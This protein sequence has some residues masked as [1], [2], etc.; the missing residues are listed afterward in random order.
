MTTQAAA[1]TLKGSTAIVTEFFKASLSSILYQRG[2]FEE[3]D[4]ETVT[5]YDTVLK[6]L[7]NEEVNEYVTGIL[8]KAS[9]WLQRGQLK[10]F[11]VVLQG[12]HSKKALERWEFNIECD[13]EATDKTKVHKS[14]KQIKQEI[15]ML[16]KQILSTNSF[17]PCLNEPLFFEIQSYVDKDSDSQGWVETERVEI[18]NA[19]EIRLRSFNTK[20]HKVEGAVAFQEEE[21]DLDDPN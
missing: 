20:I 18:A 21:E 5:K 7:I 9:V 13:P 3:K 10:K 8:E 19:Q 16:I 2:V 4:F 6:M 12:L 17:L 15:Q 11:V 14:P 1:I